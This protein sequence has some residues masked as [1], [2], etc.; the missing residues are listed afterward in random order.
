MVLLLTGN[1]ILLE[2]HSVWS[3]KRFYGYIWHSLI[4]GLFTFVQVFA[5]YSSFIPSKYGS[6]IILPLK[7]WW[8][9]RWL[10]KKKMLYFYSFSKK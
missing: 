6:N 4:Y 3:F 1:K 7:K 9:L 2:I 8:V 5:K 10:C